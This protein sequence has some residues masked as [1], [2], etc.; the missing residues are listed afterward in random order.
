[1]KKIEFAG[2][3]INRVKIIDL[4]FNKAMLLAY[5][6]LVI[7]VYGIYEVIFERY[8]A[9]GVSLLDISTHMGNS[10]LIHTIK[11]SVFGNSSEVKR[12]EPW[13]IYIAVKFHHVVPFQ[14]QNLE[15]HLVKS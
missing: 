1:M 4:L 14:K 11:E 12:E 10:D 15:I 2:L 8:F 5:L 7:G 6:L 9:H 13:N 3:E